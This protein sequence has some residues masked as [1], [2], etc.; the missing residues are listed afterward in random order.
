MGWNASGDRRRRFQSLSST[1]ALALDGAL[2]MVVAPACASCASVLDAPLSGPV[3]AACWASVP[4]LPLSWRIPHSTSIDAVLSAGAYD[5]AL[6]NIIHAWKFERRQGLARPLARLLRERC[7]EAFAGV[8]VAVPVPMTPWRRWH[9]GFNQA[10]DLAA[11]LGLRAVRALARW[12]PRPAQAT[13]PSSLRR[14]NLEAAVFVPSWRRRDV[15]G[16]VVLLVDD[17]VTTGATLETCARALR[18]AGA[19]DVRA[20]TV[21]RTLLKATRAT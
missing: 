19:A 2:A 15:E 14:I 20:V 3:C 17:V 1:A 4:P 12:R 6:K 9:R 10:E 21:A 16:R 13:L 8:D 5:G 18:D 11:H 7:E